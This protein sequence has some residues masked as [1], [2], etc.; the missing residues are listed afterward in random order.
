MVCHDWTNCTGSCVRLR[1]SHG[2]RLGNQGR[3][4]KGEIR[5][6]YRPTGTDMPCLSTKRRDCRNCIQYPSIASLI[7]IE[8]P[9]PLPR[10]LV[11]PLVEVLR[12]PRGSCAPP[13]PINHDGKKRFV[14]NGRQM[15]TITAFI[16][17][18]ILL[19][20]PE[21]S[22]STRCALLRWA[23]TAQLLVCA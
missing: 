16:A 18:S 11:C 13:P 21:Y 17:V 8:T 22:G 7:V 4:E 5:S 3:G 6:G 23:F 15:L 14:T 2:H 1:S 9:T 12:S 10:D 19:C 20:H